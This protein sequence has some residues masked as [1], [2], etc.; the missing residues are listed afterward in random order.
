MDTGS[1]DARL[2]A[3]ARKN[4]NCA[5]FTVGRFQGFGCRASCRGFQD[6]GSTVLIKAS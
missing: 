2:T 5:E 4:R 6:R 1:S 3:R